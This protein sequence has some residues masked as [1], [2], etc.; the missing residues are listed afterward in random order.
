[1]TNLLHCELLDVDGRVYRVLSAPRRPQQSR[2]KAQGTA[3]AEERYFEAEEQT[4]TEGGQQ[5]GAAAA[6]AATVSSSGS[7]ADAEEAS[8]PIHQEG[9][10]YVARMHLDAEVRGA[11]EA[12]AAGRVMGTARGHASVRRSSTLRPAPHGPASP[13]DSLLAAPQ[14]LTAC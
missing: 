13:A 12:E 6:A 2:R 14:R 11:R 3:T 9:D 8:V 5:G 1:M 7:E 10:A 4:A